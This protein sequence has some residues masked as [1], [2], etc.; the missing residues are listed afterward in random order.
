VNDFITRGGLSVHSSMPWG[1]I[2]PTTPIHA[3]ETGVSGDRTTIGWGMTYYDSITA[4]KKVVKPGDVITKSKADSLLTGLVNNYVTTLKGQNWYQK[5]WNKMSSQQQG[6]LL[7]YGYNQP[8]HL[9]GT[10]APK[11]YAALSRGDMNAVAANVDRG[12]P[13][14][15]KTEKRLILSGPRNLNTATAASSAKPKVIVNRVGGGSSQPNI[16]QQVQDAV[17]F[18]PNLIFNPRRLKRELGMRR[19]R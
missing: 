2:K 18:I 17:T 9:L 12:L 15:E 6:G 10:G 14:R 4:G 1:R 5:Y 3:Y 8:A 11:M 7:A 19:A 16:V 13:Q